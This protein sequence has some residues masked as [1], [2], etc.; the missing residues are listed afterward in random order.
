MQLV[1][2]MHI[3]VRCNFTLWN[4]PISSNDNS[5]MG[6]I[7]M[8]LLHYTCLHYRCQWRCL[9]SRKRLFYA[10]YADRWKPTFK[11][12]CYFLQ[13]L[14]CCCVCFCWRESWSECL[15]VCV[16]STEHRTK[17]AAFNG[18]I[19][20]IGQS[21]AEKNAPQFH[22]ITVFQ[23]L[24]DWMLVLMNTCTLVCMSEHCLSFLVP[25]HLVPEAIL[26]CSRKAHAET[27]VNQECAFL[28]FYFWKFLRTSLKL[29]KEV[30]LSLDKLKTNVEKRKEKE[31]LLKTRDQSLNCRVSHL[32]YE[33]TFDT[34]RFNS[35]IQITRQMKN[36]CESGGHWLKILDVNLRSPC[37]ATNS[38][39]SVSK[40]PSMKV[41]V[42]LSPYIHQ[43]AWDWRHDLRSRKPA[44]SAV[45]PPSQITIH[46]QTMNSTQ[47]L[48]NIWKSVLPLSHLHATARSCSIY[49]QPSSVALMGCRIVSKWKFMPYQRH[50]SIVCNRF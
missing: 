22:L 41:Q 12:Q 18:P 33:M 8:H 46:I 49:I 9:Q 14:F 30:R 6:L 1:K 34:S 28:L 23:T 3:L 17:D 35:F 4:T 31:A 38:S 47:I 20:Q 39:H 44:I 45:I 25:R 48:F 36:L 42:V 2:A 29:S 10:L 16:T 15:P 43:T 19:T 13:G 7:R 40:E 32:F 24:K 5:C 27:T 21:M 11:I 37:S 50:K 26:L